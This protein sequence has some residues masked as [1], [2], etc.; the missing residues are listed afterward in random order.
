MTIASPQPVDPAQ[1]PRPSIG[2]SRVGSGEKCGTAPFGRWSWRTSRR[3]L[4]Q[5]P[6]AIRQPAGRARKDLRVAGPAQPFVALRAIGR[7]LDEVRPL[8]PDGVQHQPVDRGLAT[9]ESARLHGDRGDRDLMDRHQLCPAGQGDTGIAEAEEGKHRR[10]GFHPVAL[11]RVVLFGAGGTEVAVVESAVRPEDLGK[12][13]LH[14]RA[15]RTL[16]GRSA[17]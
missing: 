3:Y 11:Q 5:E 13:H 17:T 8:R 14:M 4:R 1:S 12:L 9:G 16:H 2:C 15:C 6:L 7:D 10:V